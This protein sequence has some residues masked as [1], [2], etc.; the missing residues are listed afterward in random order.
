MTNLSVSSMRIKCAL[1]VSPFLFLV[2]WFLQQRLSQGS[3][4]HTERSFSKAS[5]GWTLRVIDGVSWGPDECCLKEL[6]YTK[7][8]SL[9]SRGDECRLSCGTLISFKMSAQTAP[10]LPS[11]APCWNST[12][13]SLPWGFP[14]G[15]VWIFLV[16]TG[17]AGS[18]CVVA[19]KGRQVFLG[20]QTQCLPLCRCVSCNCGPPE[21]EPGAPQLALSTDLWLSF[22]LFL[23]LSFLKWEGI[24]IFTSQGI[25]VKQTKTMKSL[26]NIIHLLFI[27]Y[28]FIHV[29]IQLIFVKSH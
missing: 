17:Q 28:A 29:F 24:K 7:S 12:P 26:S 8:T 3:L 15:P 19:N 23:T 1:A 20:L 21:A 9:C 13:S 5:R 25:K 18:V 22:D 2:L 11:V 6:V 14:W 27:K 4:A 10:F 16:G